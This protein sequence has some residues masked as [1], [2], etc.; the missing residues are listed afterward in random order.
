MWLLLAF[1]CGFTF[2]LIVTSRRLHLYTPRHMTNVLHEQRLSAQACFTSGLLLA[3]SLYLFHA[4]YI[5]RSIVL[6]TVVLVAIA[7][8]LRRLVYRLLLYR[9]FDRGLDTRNVLIVGIGAEAQA[10]RKHPRTSP[11]WAVLC[12]SIRSM[13]CRSSST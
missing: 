13:S 5:P 3:G 8:G 11:A 6:I 10:L 12:A 9:H 1:L 2:V 4:T 7:L